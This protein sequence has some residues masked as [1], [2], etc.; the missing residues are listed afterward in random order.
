MAIW[1]GSTSAH[2]TT[3][4]RCRGNEGCPEIP[5]SGVPGRVE[6]S[7]DP[8]LSGQAEPVNDFDTAGLNRPGLAGGFTFSGVGASGKPGAVQL[9][10]SA[11]QWAKA[12]AYT[13]ARGS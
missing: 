5:L 8:R 1:T 12:R 9:I 2:T 3:H 10:H 11:V 13:S 4:A 6:L 7:T